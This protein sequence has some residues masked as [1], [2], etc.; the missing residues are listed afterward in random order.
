MVDPRDEG[1][2]R[3]VR[4]PVTRRNFMQ[5]AGMGAAGV[6]FLAACARQS[7]GT[8]GA[9]PT[10]TLQ[11]ASPANPVTWPISASNPPIASGLMPEKDATLQ[12]Y[13]Y[14]DYLDP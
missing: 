12:V 8:A 5:L 11:V 6:P 3:P 4:R 10:Q 7:N 1:R 2:R 13:N 9:T 14:T